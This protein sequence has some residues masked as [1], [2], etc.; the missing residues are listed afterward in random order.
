MKT[1]IVIP[2]HNE[3]DNILNLFNEVMNSLDSL[4]GESEVIIVNDGSYDG[5]TEI[6]GE[7]VKKDKRLTVIN[8]RRNFGQTA[9]MSAGFKHAKGEVIIAMDG[10]LQN[11]PKDFSVLLNKIN[12]GYDLVSGWRKNRQ[13]KTLSRKIPS[14]IANWLIGKVTGVSLHDYGCSLKAYRRDM[15]EHIELYGEMHRFIPAHAAMVG[16]KITEIPVSHRAR[17]HG[18]TKYGISRTFRVVLDLLTIKFLMRFRSRPIHFIGIPGTI[19]IFSGLVLFLYLLYLKFFLSENIG[20]R[21]LL[22]VSIFLMTLGIQFL[23]MGLLAELITRTYHE[24][25]DK[26]TYIISSILKSNS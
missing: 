20:S 6:L 8:F 16:A 23:G 4:E 14:K 24:S 26:K 3:K 25:T 15:L 7:L 13:D 11:D 21:P 12:E 17:V 19:S 10:D 2:V 1:S 18:V 9:A 22:V 5:T